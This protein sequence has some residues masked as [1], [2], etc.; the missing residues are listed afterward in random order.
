MWYAEAGRR[1][2]GQGAW[3]GANAVVLALLVMQRRNKMA[4]RVAMA[5][6]TVELVAKLGGNT[7]YRGGRSLAQFSWRMDI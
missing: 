6:T 2:G 1:A 7:Q 3:Y 5:A 4:T